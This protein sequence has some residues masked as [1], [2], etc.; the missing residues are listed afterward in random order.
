MKIYVIVENKYQ[1]EIEVKKSIKK[2]IID[3]LIEKIE[4]MYYPE[5]PFEIMGIDPTKEEEEKGE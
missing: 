5:V 2:K 3:S 1:H 4:K